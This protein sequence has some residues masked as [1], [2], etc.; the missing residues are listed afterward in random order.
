MELNL[1]PNQVT[2]L[3]RIVIERIREI[4]QRPGHA[5]PKSL[6]RIKVLLDKGLKGWGRDRIKNIRVPSKV[7]EA[8]AL[9]GHINL[10]RAKH[11]PTG[12]FYGPSKEAVAENPK[13]GHKRVIKT[14]LRKTQKTYAVKPSQSWLDEFRDRDGVLIR[15]RAFEFSVE[16]L[17]P[18]GWVLA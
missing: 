9:A 5:N 12:M 6:K 13:P 3:K 7:K 10:Y 16:R 1:S 8:Q 15:G 11:E 4:E 2:V 18:N 14:N 17:T